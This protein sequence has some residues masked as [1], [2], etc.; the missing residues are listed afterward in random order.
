MIDN[1]KS[2][3]DYMP[4]AVMLRELHAAGYTDREIGEAA[5]MH[6]SSINRLRNG[7]TTKINIRQY[8]LIYELFRRVYPRENVEVAS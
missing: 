5:G 4:S 2:P 1:H 6:T 3:S 8:F 7:T